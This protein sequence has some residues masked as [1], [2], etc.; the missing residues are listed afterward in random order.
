MPMRNIKILNFVLCALCFELR[1]LVFGLWSLGFGLWAFGFG[2][3]TL[4]RGQRS[5]FKAQ[6]SKPKD[7]SPK[8]KD[9]RSQL[10]RLEQLLRNHKIFPFGNLD[11]ACTALHNGDARARAFYQRGLIRQARVHNINLVI[12]VSQ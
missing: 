1:S 7:Q 10:I 4:T 8:P 3:W 5:K 11:I 6:S 2:L 12:S 9:H